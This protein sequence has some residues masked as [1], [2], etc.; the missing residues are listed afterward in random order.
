MT[1]RLPKII[2]RYRKDGRISLVCRGR[3]IF[4]S[5]KLFPFQSIACFM[6]GFRPGSEG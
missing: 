1:K 3:V 5:S 2:R 6:E 4:T